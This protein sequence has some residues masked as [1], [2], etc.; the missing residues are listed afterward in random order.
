[1][2][3]DPL[4]RAL[5]SILPPTPGFRQLGNFQTADFCFM[6]QTFFRGGVKIYG[7]CRRFERLQPLLSWIFNTYEVKTVGQHYTIVKQP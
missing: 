4:A 7:R 3:S 5:R 6:S 1:M 2:R